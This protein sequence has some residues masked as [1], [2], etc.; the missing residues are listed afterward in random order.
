MPVGILDA[1]CKRYV[2]K[3]VV[4]YVFGWCFERSWLV[5]RAR[6]PVNESMDACTS[7]TT[8]CRTFGVSLDQ[9]VVFRTLDDVKSNAAI[10]VLLGVVSK[11]FVDE[12]IDTSFE[13]L[14]VFFELSCHVK[15]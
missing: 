8:E 12:A 7:V 3:Q 15:V 6:L 13:N 10:S 5:D 1:G 11:K 2:V 4:T 9:L 14:D